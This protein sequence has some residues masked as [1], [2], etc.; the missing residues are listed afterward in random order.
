MKF[1]R[2]AISLAPLLLFIGAVPALAIGP[3]IVFFP[4]ASET[5]SPQA[6]AILQNT[7]Q[8]FARIAGEPGTGIVLI[9]HTDRAGARAANLGLSC[10]RAAS[11][12]AYL[13]SLG[14][15][16]ERIVAVGRGEDMPLVDTEDGVAE[17]QNR[18]VEVVFAVARGIAEARAGASAC[19][20]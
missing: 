7:A 17:A 18:R 6:Q 9:G 15:S 5:V 3:L 13:I 2:V 20:D 10:R 8:I 1:R 14:I 16:P 11:V 19:G 12:R 4:T